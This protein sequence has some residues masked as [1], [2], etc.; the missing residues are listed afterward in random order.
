MRS[1]TI[2]M[3]PEVTL[4]EI[5]DFHRLDAMK[6]VDVRGSDTTLPTSA[7]DGDML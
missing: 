7:K 1:T 2:D 4:P 5:F 3:L 6:P